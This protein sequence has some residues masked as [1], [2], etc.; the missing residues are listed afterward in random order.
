M[1]INKRIQTECLLSN[2]VDQD[3]QA[4][5]FPLNVVQYC[6]LMPRFS[7]INNFITPDNHLSSYI[8]SIIGVY[9]FVWLLWSVVDLNILNLLV[10]FIM[11]VPP[12]VFDMQIVYVTQSVV[13][14]KNELIAWI[15]KMKE[16]KNTHIT[17]EEE[18]V[19]SA[20]SEYDMFNAYTDIIKAFRLSNKVYEFSDQTMFLTIFLVILNFKDLMLLVKLSIAC[21]NFYTTINLA[22]SC[23]AQILSNAIP[24]GMRKTCKNVLRLN[25]ASLRKMSAFGVFDLDATFPLRLFSVMVIYTVVLLQFA[26]LS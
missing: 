25:R 3:F 11:I 21:E 13:M 14:I 6:F 22:E 9:V 4:M 20:V 12:V 17:P 5:L 18:V 19:Y 8:Q 16:Y 1:K 15:H 10:N 2:I 7:I 24:T 26:F 23:C